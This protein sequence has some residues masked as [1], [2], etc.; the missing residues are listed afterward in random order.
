MHINYQSLDIQ[1][2]VDELSTVGYFSKSRENLKKILGSSVGK[3]M[4]IEAQRK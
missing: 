3:V 2:A 1:C 4:K